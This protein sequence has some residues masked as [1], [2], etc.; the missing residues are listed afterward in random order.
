MW[1]VA[2]AFLIYLVTIIFRTALCTPTIAVSNPRYWIPLSVALLADGVAGY[3]FNVLMQR[4]PTP[5]TSYS[6]VLTILSLLA[7]GVIAGR[8]AFSHQE[9]AQDERALGTSLSVLLALLLFLLFGAV[10]YYA[11]LSSDISAAPDIHIVI[12]VIMGVLLL[13]NTVSDYWDYLE[14]TE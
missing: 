8:L 10:A 7:A 1:F 3:G 2:A 9:I 6:A 5:D 13:A 14:R 4:S 11:G 12:P